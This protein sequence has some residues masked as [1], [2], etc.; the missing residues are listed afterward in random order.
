MERSRVIQ[1]ELTQ[2]EQ[3]LQNE[4]T[5]SKTSLANAERE[6]DTAVRRATD[7]E[8]EM[9]ELREKKAHAETV[10]SNNARSLEAAQAELK[11]LKDELS[12]LV[13]N[14]VKRKIQ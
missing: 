1:I 12:L 11:S 7:I 6:R 5:S 9:R 2:R 13:E 4:L 3:I 10:S 14:K 8:T